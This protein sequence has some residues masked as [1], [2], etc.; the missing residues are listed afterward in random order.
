MKNKLLLLFGLWTNPKSTTKKIIRKKVSEWKLILV[1]FLFFILMMLPQVLLNTKSNTLNDPI[2]WI[3]IL[4]SF[5]LSIGMFYLEIWIIDLLSHY[6]C[7]A[8]PNYKKARIAATLTLFPITIAMALGLVLLFIPFFWGIFLFL[9]LMI[10]SSVVVFGILSIGFGLKS[11][12]Q[13]FGM[14]MIVKIIFALMTLTVIY[15]IYQDDI[16]YYLDQINFYNPYNTEDAHFV[17]DE[18]K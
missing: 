1:I 10:L 6:L 14:V 12:W 8:K 16:N 9:I 18:L 3:S 13:A 17:P 5:L 4:V 2:L 15:F 11:S 7:K